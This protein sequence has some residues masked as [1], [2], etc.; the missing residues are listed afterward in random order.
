M[1]ELPIASGRDV[2]RT[3]EGL[4]FRFVRQRGSHVLLRRGSKTCVV[5]LHREVKL[6][7]LRGVLRQAGVTTG[8]FLDAF[9]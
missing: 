9:N 6:G 4:G 1:P 8:E 3:L 5:P 2:V 7:T